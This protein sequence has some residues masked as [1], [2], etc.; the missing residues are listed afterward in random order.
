MTVDFAKLAAALR[1]RLVRPDDP[2]YAWV[3]RR[4]IR[5]DRDLLPAVVAKCASAEDIAETLAY[6]RAHGMPFAVRAGGHSYADH[7]STEGL[8]IDVSGLDT[9]EFESAETTQTAEEAEEAG[10]AGLAGAAGAAG[11]RGTRVRVGAGTRVG[12]LAQRLA[13]AGRLL[14]TGTCPTVGIGGSALVGG[15]GLVGRAYG[16]T[17][18]QVR[19][20][21]V[22]LAD[23]RLV[24][25][26]PTNHPELFW[27]LRGAG[28]GNFGV[29]TEF[30]FDTAP[31]PGLTA[32]G[33]VWP[34]RDAAAV[35]AGWQEYAPDA[36]DALSGSLALLATSQLHHPPS[37]HFFGAVAAAPDPAAHLVEE[38]FD[39]L[40]PQPRRSIVR[41]LDPPAAA[42]Y[43]AGLADLYGNETYQPTGPFDRPGY[44]FT[45][46]GFFTRRLPE[47]AIAELVARL[48]GDRDFVEHRE[49]EFAPWQGAYGRVPAEETAFAHRSARFLVRITVAVG[50]SATPYRLAAARRWL[51]RAWGTVRSFSSGGVYPGYA[52]PDLIGWAR[53]YYGDG[54]PRL[55][56]IKSRYD[57]ENLFSF[58]Q[59]LPLAE[60]S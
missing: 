5:L 20:V 17:L 31:I 11:D 1:G 12:P 14:P 49:L 27:A 41:V 30:V 25:A 32:F 51:D 47:Q 46:S 13:R 2:E 39:A 34:L 10:A 35:I 58:P 37:V 36:P 60:A 42:R 54:L 59:S 8:L 6:A 4:N 56:R 15:F 38:F 21:R 52:D 24:T 50:S 43:Q 18:D 55:C 57:P 29:A 3:R 44:Q 23:G 7:S 40:G 22:V 45:R 48:D 16:L 53:A 19:A 28:A 33:A 26:D 9:I